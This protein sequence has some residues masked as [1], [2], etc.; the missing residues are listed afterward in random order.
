MGKDKI[1][2]GAAGCGFVL[3]FLCSVS[4]LFW[5]FNTWI[6]P[7]G[8]ISADEAFPGVLGSCCCG[9]IALAITAGGA[10][11]ALKMK[12]DAAAPV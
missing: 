4:F 6:E 8:A 12:K 1:G 11:F 5:G 3:F 10:I 2:W 7:G 9:F